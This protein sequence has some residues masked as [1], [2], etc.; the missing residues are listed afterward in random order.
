[1]RLCHA[2][3]VVLTLII[4]DTLVGQLLELLVFRENPRLGE[5]KKLIQILP[6][7]QQRT[8]LLAVLQYIDGEYLGSTSASII[9]LEDHQSTE[10]ISNCAALV[11]EFTAG[12]DMLEE[13]LSELCV[14][15][16]NSILMRSRG[17]RRT[18]LAALSH[19]EG[20]I[21]LNT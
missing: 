10:A 12:I 7:Y 20:M 1:M 13:F 11:K 19:D 21:R 2:S 15:V 8:I 5:F 16:E 18:V 4:Q 17:L 3:N 9:P 14:K 6:L